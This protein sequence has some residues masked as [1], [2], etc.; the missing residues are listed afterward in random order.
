MILDTEAAAAHDAA[1]LARGGCRT[2]GHASAATGSRDRV[3]RRGARQLLDDFTDEQFDQLVLSIRATTG[4]EAL[5][6]LVD[7]VA[8]LSRRTPSRSWVGPPKRSFNGRPRLHPQHPAEPPRRAAPRRGRVPTRPDRDL[9]RRLAPPQRPVVNVRRQRPAPESQKNPGASTESIWSVSA[10]TRHRPRMRG[11]TASST[12]APNAGSVSFRNR[13]P[14]RHFGDATRPSIGAHYGTPPP[15]STRAP[16]RR[17]ARKRPVR[18]GSL[19]A[20]LTGSSVARYFWRIRGEV[21][22]RPRQARPPAGEHMSER[23]A[24]LLPAVGCFPV[25]A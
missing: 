9:R 7:V 5:V 12:Y 8:G 22:D 3:D 4:I 18:S 21:D 13:D 17:Y 1:T 15:L 19:E 20:R 10:A 16:S 24:H 11:A 2:N 14:E 25:R 23:P 6:W